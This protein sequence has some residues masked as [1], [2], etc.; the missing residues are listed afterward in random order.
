MNT[1]PNTRMTPFGRKRLLFQNIE[2]SLRLSPL[3][4]Q[5]RISIHNAYKWLAPYRLSS[6]AALRHRQNV[7]SSQWRRFNPQKLH[8]L[9]TC[10]MRAALSIALTE[11]WPHRTR[12]WAEC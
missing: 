8:P 4:A 3:A 2:E 5:A 7:C 9:W 6:A 12:L 10:A 1:H 11:T